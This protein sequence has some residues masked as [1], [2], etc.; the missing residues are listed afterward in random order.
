MSAVACLVRAHGRHERRSGTQ[1][2]IP[3]HWEI[4]EDRLHRAR[5]LGCRATGAEG[6]PRVTREEQRGKAR[7]FEKDR[8]QYTG[9]APKCVNVN[10]PS[11]FD[12]QRTGRTSRWHEHYSWSQKCKGPPQN[13]TDMSNCGTERGKR[14][15]DPERG[16][17]NRRTRSHTTVDRSQA[18]N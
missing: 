17:A 5:G 15:A 3:E 12:A 18:C 10:T 14:L 13:G 7:A 11:E 8:R 16:G 9:A 1:Q 4:G 6:M 2:R